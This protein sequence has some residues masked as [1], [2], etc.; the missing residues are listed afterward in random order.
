MNTQ[1]RAEVEDDFEAVMKLV[2]DYSTSLESS[3][4]GD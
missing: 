2:D 1:E 4:A 3:E